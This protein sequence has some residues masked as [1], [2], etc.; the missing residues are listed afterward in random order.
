MNTPWWSGLLIAV[1][2]A[3]LGASGQQSTAMHL[4][5]TV[6]DAKSRRPISGARVSVDGGRAL[7][8]DTTDNNGSFDLPLRLAVRAGERVRVRVERDGYEPYDEAVAASDEIPLQVLLVA[9]GKS[10]HSSPAPQV[11]ASCHLSDRQSPCE[12]Y[13]SIENRGTEAA[14]DASVGFV[15]LLPI[16]T[17]SLVSG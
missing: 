14:R 4:R 9:R 15:G 16:K 10:N 5:G 12:L 6:D 11:M 13:C 17:Q 3:C 8:D 7:H 1:L 2:G